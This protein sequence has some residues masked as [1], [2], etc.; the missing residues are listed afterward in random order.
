MEQPEVRE[1]V[2]DLLLAE[3]AAPGRS[4]RREALAPKRL[5]VALGVG[6]GGEEDDDLP[7]IGLAGVDELAHAARDAPRLSRAPVL[8][9]VGEARLVGDEQLDRMAEHR[10]GELRRRRQRLVVVAE[11]VARRDG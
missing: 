8:A 11:R 4:I 9:R 1:K 7:G 3:V 2:D 5:L 6:A 10:I